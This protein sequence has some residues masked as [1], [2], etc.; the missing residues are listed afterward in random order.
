MSAHTIT[1]IG[2]GFAALTAVRELRKRDKMSRITVI[3]PKPEF[4]FLPSLIWIPSGIRKGGA[5]ASH[6]KLLQPNPAALGRLGLKH[7]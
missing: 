4:I 7:D 2:S 5:C 6:Y 3:S 1:V